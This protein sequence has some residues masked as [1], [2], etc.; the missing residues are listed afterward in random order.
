MSSSAGGHWC[1]GALVSVEG[2]LLLSGI[3]P[4]QR[5]PHVHAGFHAGRG[6]LCQHCGLH[7]THVPLMLTS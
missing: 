2:L 5:E 1:M 7:S 3:P 4:I 6:W